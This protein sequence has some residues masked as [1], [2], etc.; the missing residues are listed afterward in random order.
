MQYAIQHIETGDYIGS[1]TTLVLCRTQS[2]GELLRAEL[3]LTEFA[4]VVVFDE[5]LLDKVDGVMLF[6]PD[7]EPSVEIDENLSEQLMDAWYEKAI[8]CAMRTAA[9]WD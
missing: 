4:D 8:L 5:T 1:G 9:G 3:G 2:D 7:I 6:H